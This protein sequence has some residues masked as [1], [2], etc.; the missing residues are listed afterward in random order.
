MEITTYVTLADMLAYTMVLISVVSL[1][2]VIFRR[3]K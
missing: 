3:K 2:Y 1:C